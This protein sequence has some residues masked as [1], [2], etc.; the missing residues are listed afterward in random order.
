MGNTAN[1][2]ATLAQIFTVFAKIGITS[3]GGGVVAYLRNALVTDNQWMT[4]E[5]FLAALEISQ[6]L[7]GLNSVNLAIIAGRKLA[8][9]SGSLAASIGIVLPGVLFLIALGL[10]YERF[11]KNPNIAAALAGIGAA[12]VGLLLQMTLK[13]GSQQFRNFWDLALILVTFY[14]VAI[15]HVSLPVVLFLVAP[16]AIILNRPQV[17]P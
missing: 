11:H 13:I 12:A 8:G 6:T 5:E 7:P 9:P 14:L 2:Q 1:S 10:L 15:L 4:D 16:I 17:K 3:F